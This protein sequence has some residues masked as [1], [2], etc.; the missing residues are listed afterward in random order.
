GQ[1][2]ADEVFRVWA[3]DHPATTLVPVDMNEAVT[4]M[5]ERARRAAR[6]A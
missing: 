5:V 1:G 6:H 3:R 2:F 4:F